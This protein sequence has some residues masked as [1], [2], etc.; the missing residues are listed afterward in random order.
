VKKIAFYL[1]NKGFSSVDTRSVLEANPGIGGSEYEILCISHLLT[2]RNNNIDVL[3]YVESEGVFPKVKYKVVE[4][5]NECTQDCIKESVDVLILD[6]KHHQK[7]VINKTKPFLNYFIWAHNFINY[8]D[9]KYFGLASNVKRIIQ[10]GKESLDLYR[11]HQ[12]FYK[13]TYINNGVAVRDID[14]YLKVIE[15]DKKRKQNVVYIGSLI[16]AKGFHLL[17]NAWKEIV[18]EVPEA[19]LFVIGSGK[20]YDRSSKLG[21]YQLADESYEKIFIK[22]ILIDGKIMPSVHFLGTLGSEKDQIL[23]KCKV[24]VPNPSGNTETF[25]ISAVEMQLMGCTITTIKCPGYLNTVHSTNLLYSNKSQLTKSVIKLLKQENH[26]EQYPQIYK[27]IS[28]NFS[29]Q[30]VI[31][32]W[33]FEIYN[34]NTCVEPNSIVENNFHLK[35]MKEKL[36]ILKLKLPFTNKIPPIERGF[37]LIK[38]IVNKL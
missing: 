23:T 3:L 38:A 13:S 17:A 11:D 2:T 32:R 5:L 16:P 14:Y 29:F 19:E 15:L 4:D 36:R 9:L 1:K 24:G 20:L 21:Y 26:N 34:V 7:N 18:K 8:N 27:F 28:D 31:E 35:I 22:D 10:V 33:E 37:N 30:N 12:S 6:Y 25:G